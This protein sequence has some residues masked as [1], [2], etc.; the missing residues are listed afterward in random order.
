[1]VEVLCFE[2]VKASRSYVRKSIL[3][4][5]DGRQKPS[6]DGKQKHLNDVDWLDASIYSAIPIAWNLCHFMP[7]Q[8]SQNSVIF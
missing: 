4:S 6:Q 7:A 2:I 3:W 5:D 1:M 8:K